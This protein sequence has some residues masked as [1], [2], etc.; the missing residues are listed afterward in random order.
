MHRDGSAA[1]NLGRDW[2][3]QDFQQFHD[4]VLPFGGADADHVLIHLTDA[5][6]RYPELRSLN[7]HTGATATIMR[8]KPGV[9]D[10]LADPSGVVRTG[11]GPLGEKKV[12]MARATA[13]GPMEE[14]ARFDPLSEPGFVPV[15]VPADIGTLWVTARRDSDRSAVYAYDL[16]GRRFG[17]Q[18]AA[19]AAVDVAGP[20]IYWW[21]RLVGLEYVVD[22]TEFIFTDDEART[23]Y[24][25]LARALPGRTVRVLGW[26]RDGTRA[27]VF[28]DGD[29]FA[30]A[31]YVFF[32]ES[33]NLI[34]LFGTH[35]NLP[36]DAL[37]PTKPVS[38][39]ARDGLALH[40]Y[41]T[42]PA[43]LPERQLPTVVLVHGGPHERDQV[44]FDPEVQFLANRGFAVL[45]INYRGSGGYGEHFMARGR[46]RWGREMQDDLDDG[47]QWLV[48]E[49]IADG[50][51]LAI[52]GA[53]YGGYAALMAAAKSPDRYRCAAS[54]AGVSDLAALVSDGSWYRFGEFSQRM[55][56]GGPPPAPDEMRESSPLYHVDRITI[57]LLLAHGKQDPTAS[58]QQTERMEAALRSAG[59][60][61]E[62]VYFDHE[63]H[64]FHNESA[65]LSFYRA[66]EKF[67]DTNLAVRE[68]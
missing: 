58:V 35:P 42:L 22:R 54:Y 9:T 67:L 17:K 37:V 2:A 32:R 60:P 59:K 50:K 53:S 63:I 36:D 19:H 6:Q 31:Y 40:G 61:V 34:E 44:A 21:G 8:A 49:G 38:F 52:Y 26:S 28:A 15:A 13:D 64:G 51:R 66:L 11:Y 18:I 48:Q 46:G 10:W 68:R 16:V 24:D 62:A 25:R 7:V 3:D 14:I 23:E 12:V 5:G 41:L 57:P 47:V 1:R 4:R 27:L 30:G 33:A 55:L 56:F 45:Q 65:R 43:K 29:R 39:K 20:A